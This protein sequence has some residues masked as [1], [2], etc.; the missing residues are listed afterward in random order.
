M[1]SHPESIVLEHASFTDLVEVFAEQIEEG[2]FTRGYGGR[3][4]L[5]LDG[6]QRRIQDR[7]RASGTPYSDVREFSDVREWP[8]HWLAAAGIELHDRVPHGR[9]TPLP[10]LVRAAQNGPVGGRIAGD[11][12]RSRGPRAQGSSPWSTGRALLDELGARRVRFEVAADRRVARRSARSTVRPLP[13]DR[14]GRLRGDVERD[15]VDAGDLVHHPRGDR[16]QQVVRQRA[17][18]A[19]IASSEVTARITIGYAYVRSSPWT[20]TERIAGSTAKHCHSSR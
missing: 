11:G 15:A 8:A 12:C 2:E 16:L 17:Q 6:E 9:R 3:A 13:L 20:P 5:T 14:R 7:L 4:N 19:V 18:S 1:F 10:H